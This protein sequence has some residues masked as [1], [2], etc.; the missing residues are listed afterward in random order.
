MICSDL[1]ERM[2]IFI[3]GNVGLCCG[4]EK[5]VFNLGNIFEEDPVGIYNGPIFSE[6]RNLMSQGNLTDIEY[7]KNCQIILSRM[8]K[9]YL[10]LTDK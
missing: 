1:L 9:Q 8:E 5:G 2:W 10:D 4:D 6:Y 3:D 7:C